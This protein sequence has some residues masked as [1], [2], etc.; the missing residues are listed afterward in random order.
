MT[1]DYRLLELVRQHG[2]RDWVKIASEMSEVSE[3][4]LTR[5][6]VRCRFQLIYRNFKKNPDF[7]LDK[8]TYKHEP[9][10]ANRRQEIIYQK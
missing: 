10:L 2:L 5:A 1:E 3:R 4:L 8:I 7:S 6:Q 9:G